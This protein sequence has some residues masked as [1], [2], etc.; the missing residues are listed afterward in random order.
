[1]NT[2]NEHEAEVIWE[3]DERSPVNGEP[4]LTVKKARGYYTYAERA[5]VDSI[6]FIL[7]DEDIEKFG[8][9]SESKPPLD[10]F[11]KEKVMSLSAF[12]GSK[13]LNIPLEEIC[14]KEVLEESG[15]DVKLKDIKFMN[16]TMVSSQMNQRCFCYIVNVTGLTPSLTEADIFNK[17]QENKFKHDKVVWVTSEEIMEHGEWKSVYIMTQLAYKMEMEISKI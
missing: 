1:M 3:S 16:V 2:M 5:G 12:G 9:I 11:Y 17:E 6:A 10:E 15:Y 8:L 4:F 7:M 13:D 14:Q